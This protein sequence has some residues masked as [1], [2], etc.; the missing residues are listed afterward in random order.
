MFLNHKGKK[1]LLARN[2]EFSDEIEDFTLIKTSVTGKHTHMGTSILGAG[3]DDGINEYGLAVTMTS[4][5]IPVVDLPYM[6]TP[7]IEGLQY[8]IVVRALLENCRNVQEALS[9]IKDMPIAFHMNMI[10]FDKEEHAA[11]IQTYAGKKAIRCITTE[12]ALLFTTNHAV[13]DDDKNLE[14]GAFKHSVQRYQYIKRN[15]PIK[16]ISHEI[17]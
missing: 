11:L 12:E 5:G 8:W 3:R 10:I 2:F 16:R 17:P 15:Y 6:K 7:C 9:Y 4:C 1:P 13:L 14:S